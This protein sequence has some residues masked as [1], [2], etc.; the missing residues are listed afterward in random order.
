VSKQKP[1]NYQDYAGEY[2]V[3]L[4]TA[5]RHELKASPT[6]L[7]NIRFSSRF[8]P[9]ITETVQGFEEGELVVLTGPTKAGKTLLA[10]SL[11]YAFS[12]SNTNSLWL[13]YEVPTE[14]FINSFPTDMFPRFFLP[15]RIHAHSIDWFEE[16]AIEAWQ[17]FGN[18]VVFIDHLHFLFDLARVRNP[19]LEIGAYVRRIK[20]FAILHGLVVFLICHIHKVDPDAELNYNS[21]RD[22][23]FIAQESDS[24]FII[25]RLLNEQGQAGREAELKLEFHRRTGA[26]GKKFQLIKMGGYLWEREKG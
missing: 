6:R 21:L 5:L 19:S 26:M 14:R 18:R 17:K 2:E 1:R 8:F 3:V 16:R 25:R 9:S 12:Q 4:S 7:F 11:T 15:R 22:S 13:S 23:S 10:Q 24:V 20:R